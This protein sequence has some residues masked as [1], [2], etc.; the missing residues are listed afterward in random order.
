MANYMTLG[1]ELNI[2]NMKF[3]NA[4][5]WYPIYHK[6]WK[7]RTDCK[8]SC[9]GTIT[10]KTAENYFL[11][12]WPVCVPQGG[13]ALGARKSMGSGVTQKQVLISTCHFPWGRDLSVLNANVLIHLF[14]EDYMGPHLQ[15]KCLVPG[16]NMIN[17]AALLSRVWA[18]FCA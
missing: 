15:G 10:S 4:Y 14:W 3:N 13:A 6:M 17:V 7:P 9:F 12:S 2:Q 16:R 11:S 5:I 8:S 18:S 1:K